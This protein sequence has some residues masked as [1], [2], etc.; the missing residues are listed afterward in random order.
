MKENLLRI[1]QTGSAGGVTQHKRDAMGCDVDQ[2]KPVV[3]LNGKT[4]T[5]QRKWA[6]FCPALGGNK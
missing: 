4:K 6:L 3:E 1:R 2:G 5:Q